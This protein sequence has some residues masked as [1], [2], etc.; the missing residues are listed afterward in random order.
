[1]KRL[2]AIMMLILL[3]VA[4]AYAQPPTQARMVQIMESKGTPLDVKF[5]VLREMKSGTGR[6]MRMA[7][8]RESGGRSG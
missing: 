3:S 8:E 6:D 7:T 5:A 1:M 2:L 4:G